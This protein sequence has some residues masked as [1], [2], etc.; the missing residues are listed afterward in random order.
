MRI[1]CSASLLPPTPFLDC[2]IMAPLTNSPRKSG[3]SQRLV[4]EVQTIVSK[5]CSPLPGRKSFLEKLTEQTPSI[6]YKGWKPN[7]VSISLS[8]PTWWLLIHL[9]L[10][11]LESQIYWR[12]F[13]SG[14]LN[15]FEFL[16][17]FENPVDDKFMCSFFRRSVILLLLPPSVLSC[18]IVGL[19]N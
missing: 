16:D 15:L 8:K 13:P 19:S 3:F 18:S 7:E 10:L 6:V 9:T 14:I 2:D 4:W 17:L 5:R 1:E 12:L 11:I